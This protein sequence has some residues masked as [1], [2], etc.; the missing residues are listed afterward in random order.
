MP[1]YAANP[2]PGGVRR[3]RSTQPKMELRSFDGSVV[4]YCAQSTTVASVGGIGSG[5]YRRFFVPGYP[6]NLTSSAGASIC[7]YYS[8][9]VFKPGTT[10][11]WEP[12]CSFNTSG[13]IF[14]GF[15]DSAEVAFNIS[16]LR[17][18]FV[19]TP[20]PATYAAYADQLKALG[21]TTSFPIWQETVVDIPLRT[22]RKRFD[23]DSTPSGSVDNLDRNMQTAMFTAIEGA[24][25]ANQALGNFWFRDVVDVE[26]MHSNVT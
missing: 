2:V 23:T 19:A 20:T 9:G 3:K 10:C 13:R 11:R 1:R 6:G 18:T 15:T 8:T 14:V 17:D 25:A 5:S 12:S 24:P 21:T 26:G 16:A 22:R 7:S 4:K